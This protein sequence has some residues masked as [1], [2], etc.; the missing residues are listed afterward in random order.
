VKRVGV[1]GCLHE[2]NSFNPRP[3]S[4]A[5]FEASALVGGPGVAAH[6]AGAHHEIGGMLEAMPAAAEVV[7]LLAA[8]AVPAGPVEER[9][10]EGIVGEILERIASESLD[11][12]LLALH[13]A[14]VAEHVRDADGETTERIRRL[15][16][17]DLPVVMTLDLHANVSERMVRNVTAATIYRSN[18]HLD[19]RD[20]GREA[21]RLMARILAGE[22]RP[23]QA[24]ETPPMAINILAQRTA[25]APMAPV[26]ARM[27]RLLAEP[28]ILSASIALGFPYADVEEMGPAFLVVADG[29]AARARHAARELAAMAWDGV[30]GWRSGAVSIDEAVRI[31][32]AAEG[33]PVTLLDMG[34]NVGGGSPGDGTLLFEALD[35]AGVAG[36]LVVL[37]D[38]AAVELCRAA[39]PGAAVELEAGGKSDDRHGRPVRLEG[40]VRLLHDGNFVEDEVRHGGQRE[41]NQGLTA[42]IETSR[43][44]TVVLTSLRLAPFSLEQILS[45]G[46]KPRRQRVLIAKGTIAPRA[47]YEPVSAR[48]QEVDTP[49]ITAANPAHFT[50]RHRRRPMF[51]FEP[52]ARYE[53]GR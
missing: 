27:E 26:Y 4:R 41:Q 6:W 39:G 15:V 42:V 5:M 17:P 22:C 49:G 53:G 20:R 34:D 38:P 46:I 10:Y 43:G 2:S 28:G 24:L 31:A 9:A 11:G 8:E 18:P 47:A 37:Y 21:A 33:T 52:E 14:M 29:D 45:L 23:V 3:T 12:V 13:G 1:A 32:A 35:A 50:Y 16:G 7:P 51:P 19:Q 30:R 40:R 48:V 44:Q 36:V 25:V